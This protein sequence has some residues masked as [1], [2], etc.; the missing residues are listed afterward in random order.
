M[1][2]VFSKEELEMIKNE[3]GSYRINKKGN[4][5]I[6]PEK[7]RRSN[8]VKYCIYKDSMNNI[9]IHRQV[10][11]ACKL[12]YYKMFRDTKG[13]VWSSFPTL[14]SALEKF[15]KYLININGK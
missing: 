8:T 6:R 3:F 2:E 11:T 1:K 4:I 12:Y 14:E 10:A 9:S 15:K 7:D 13:G 5:E